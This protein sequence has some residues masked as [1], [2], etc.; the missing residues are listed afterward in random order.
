MKT[1]HPISSFLKR[2]LDRMSDGPGRSGRNLQGVQTI[3]WGNGV[4]GSDRSNLN[5]RLNIL[6]SIYSGHV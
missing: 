3:L 6:N 2:L 4:S 1:R 5:L